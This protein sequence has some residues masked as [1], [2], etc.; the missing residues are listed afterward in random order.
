MFFVRDGFNDRLKSIRIA[1]HG[2]VALGIYLAQTNFEWIIRRTL[3]ILD[4]RSGANLY[5][6]KLT[7]YDTL[8]QYS[9]TWD[10]LVVLYGEKHPDAKLI[11]L[12]KVVSEW[13]NLQNKGFIA[14]HPVVRRSTGEIT[15]TYS[16]DR[17]EML[18]AAAENVHI[19]SLSIGVDVFKRLPRVRRK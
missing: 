19:Y 2:N 14:H 8:K 5:G 17:L 3:L 7:R 11:S 13:H 15:T 18:L 10:Q 16:K 4:H 9:R 12:E 6:K 1:Y